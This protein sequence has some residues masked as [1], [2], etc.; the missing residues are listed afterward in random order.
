MRSEEEDDDNDD[1][2]DV[3]LSRSLFVFSRSAPLVSVAEEAK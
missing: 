3:H 1:L 2:V